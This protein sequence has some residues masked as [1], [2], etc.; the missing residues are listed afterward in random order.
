MSAAVDLVR[1]SF[2]GSLIIEN[3]PLS[4]RA[5]CSAFLTAMWGDREGWAAFAAGIDPYVDSSTGK[6]RH[7]KFEQFFYRWP[8]EADKAISDV[9][10][11]SNAGASD[12]YV[13]PMLRTARERK[14]ATGAGGC[15]AWADLD[16]A[17][18]EQRR[19][20]IASF[21]ADARVVN[22]GTGHHLYVKLDD[23][24]TPDDIEAVNQTLAAALGGDH[25][26]SNESLLRPPGT[27]NL[28]PRTFNGELPALVQAVTL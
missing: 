18:T 16:G 21:G 15:W 3:T 8:T 7:A 6:Y 27:W 26:W 25:K 11:M 28:K 10:N 4:R 14:K 19:D 22:S 12:M 13:S 24:H 5:M 9:Q 20:V 23:W 17:M 2:P 1:R